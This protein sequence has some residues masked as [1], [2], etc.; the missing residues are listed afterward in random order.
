MGQPDVSSL[1]RVRVEI[2]GSQNCRIVG[3]SQPVLIMIDPI[4]FTRTRT[5]L[6]LLLAP[7]LTM[8]T[9]MMADHEGGDLTAPRRRPAAARAPDGSA[10]L[11]DLDTA[12][13]QEIADAEAAKAGR[14]PWEIAERTSDAEIRVRAPANDTHTHTHTRR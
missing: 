5:P 7:T 6:L 10:L 8:M 14:K 4:I 13:A 12:Q 9:M 1:L 2:M 11:L 3:E